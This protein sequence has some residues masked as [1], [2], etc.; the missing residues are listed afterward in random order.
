MIHQSFYRTYRPQ[1]FEEMS[2]QKHVKRTLKNALLHERTSHAYLFSGPRG[3]GKTSAAKIF[4]KALNC[5]QPIDGEPCNECNTCLSITEG[6]HT[7]VI[8]FDAASN[9]RVEEIREIIEK[10]HFAPAAAKFKVYIIDEVHM[11]SNSA[12]NALLKTLEEPPAHVV[13]IL[14]T[15]EPHQLPLTIISRC[16]RFDFK[17]LTRH[18]LI[19]RM[20]VVLQDVGLEAE[21]RALQTIAQAASGGMRDALS[22]LDQIASFSDQVIREEDALL[23]TGSV[24]EETFYQLSQAVHAGDAGKA[25]TIIDDIM[26][27]GKDP[28]RFVEDSMTFFRDLLLMKAAP[29]Q[30]D[31]LELIVQVEKFQ[32]LAKHYDA[33]TLYEYIRILSDAQKE[34]RRSNHAKIYVESAVLKLVHLEQETPQQTPSM[35]MSEEMNAHLSKLNERVNELQRQLKEKAQ[36]APAPAQEKRPERSNPRSTYRIP[37]DRI[38][39]ILKSATRQDLQKVQQLWAT[40]MQSLAATDAALLRLSEPVAANDEQVI[41]SFQHEIHCSM[42]ANK[43]QLVESL[44]EQLTQRLQKE[45]STVFIPQE[46]WGPLREESIARLMEQK[47]QQEEQSPE[48]QA[49]EVEMFSEQE[50]VRPHIQKAEELFGE[51]LVEIVKD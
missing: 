3:T 50:E 38:R 17:P 20:E 27:E 39:H 18:E 15:T 51:A 45:T 8:E 40:A 21:P 32:P 10:V 47:N 24:G 4:A 28:F 43:E 49:V 16:Q 6:S 19:D 35:D 23:I 9:S 7:D 34:M 13:F 14:A 25:L 11:L 37:K 42:A 31:L 1:T 41:I 29:E 5:E 33:E 46:A 36:V 30:T 2:G 26:Q 48:Q 44:N 12:F 22:M